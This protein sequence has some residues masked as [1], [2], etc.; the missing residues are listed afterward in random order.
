MGTREH[1]LK[2]QRNCANTG[3][4]LSVFVSPVLSSDLHQLQNFFLTFAVDG[5][6][7]F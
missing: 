7:F 2:T 5:N 6:N 3:K 1:K 4:I